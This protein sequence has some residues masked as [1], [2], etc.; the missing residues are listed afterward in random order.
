[1]PPVASPGLRWAVVAGP[2]A[3]IG[4]GLLGFP[5]AG[6]F[7]AYPPAIAKPLILLIEA[8]MTLS[9]AAALAMLVA[10]P[11]ERQP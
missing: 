9:V 10:G 4:V 8:A 1:L 3:F 6:D 11:P 7:L 2:L 5:L